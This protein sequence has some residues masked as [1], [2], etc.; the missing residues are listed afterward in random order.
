MGLTLLHQILDDKI[1][2]A[3]RGLAACTM[4]IVF[5]MSSSSMLSLLHFYRPQ[6]RR[7]INDTNFRISTMAKSLSLVAKTTLLALPENSD[8]VPMRFVWS[9]QQQLCPTSCTSRFGG[10]SC[11]QVGRQC[12]CQS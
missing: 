11:V 7:V 12:Q 6:T 5:C 8:I 1:M 9:C 2:I 3:A 4:A 10:G